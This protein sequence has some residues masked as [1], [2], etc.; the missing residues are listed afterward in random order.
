MAIGIGI[1]GFAHGHVNCYCQKWIDNPEWGVILKCGW[2][3]DIERLQTAVKSFNIESTKSV[4]KLLDRND[5]DAV[6]ITSETSMHADLV[7]KSAQAG[8]DIILQKPISLTISEADRIVN[9]VNNSG[10]KFTM[11]W[12]MRVDPQNL[13]MK[14]LLENKTL[15]KT[16]MIRRKH[17]LPVCLNDDFATSWHVNPK[18]NRDIWADDIAHPADFLYW[19]LGLPESVTAE[20]ETLHNPKMPND[21]GIAIFKY[22]NGPIAEICSSFTCL[23]GENTTEITC[24]FGSVIQ[25]FGDVPS[26]NITKSTDSA[27]L[28]WYDSRTGNWEN[29]KIQSPDNHV[30]RL[31]DLA[32]PLAEYLNGKRPALASAEEGKDVLRIVLASLLSSK[33]GKRIN[34]D[35]EDIYNI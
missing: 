33:L 25:N 9:A 12:Q 27:G 6:V 20:I 17:G 21:N 10:V 14:E 28:K 11:T 34:I 16:F 29:S 31:A 30:E 18:H 26:C 23:A 5:I 13:K 32:Q 8:K 3:H 22:S 2:D 19:L 7:E 15:G 35:N 24:E 1:L 4:D